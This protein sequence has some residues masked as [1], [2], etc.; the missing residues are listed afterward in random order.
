MTGTDHCRLP[1]ES[2]VCHITDRTIMHLRLDETRRH[3]FTLTHPALLA[4]A[5][6][7]LGHSRSRPVSV[8]Y[9]IPALP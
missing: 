1:G 5:V 2:G 7:S 4:G 9:R 6:G 8:P 3:A